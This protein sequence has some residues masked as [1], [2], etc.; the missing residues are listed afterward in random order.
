MRLCGNS[1]EIQSYLIWNTTNIVETSPTTQ[2]T[3]HSCSVVI[4]TFTSAVQHE[5]SSTSR[6]STVLAC[7]LVS[8]TSPLVAVTCYKINTSPLVSPITI[9]TVALQMLLTNCLC[10][11]TINRWPVDRICG[12][13]NKAIFHYRSPTWLNALVSHSFGTYKLL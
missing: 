10:N 3:L 5:M 9:R 2:A 4:N 6:A 12:V 13:P 1:A 8:N 11:E 7:R